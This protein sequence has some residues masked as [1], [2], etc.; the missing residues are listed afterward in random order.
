MRSEAFK[1]KHRPI[2]D[3]LEE[4]KSLCQPLNEVPS[5]YALIALCDEALGYAKSMQARL[6]QNKTDMIKLAYGGELSHER[7]IELLE[8]ARAAK[9]DSETGEGK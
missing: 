9:A 1:H 6:Q 5:P 4:I 7:I 3:V 8:N 2:C